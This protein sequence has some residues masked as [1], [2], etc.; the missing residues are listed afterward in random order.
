[1]FVSS[2]GP[3]IE[4]QVMRLSDDAVSAEQHL[5]VLRNRPFR[6]T[7]L[8]HQEIALSR[9]L[10]PQRL[11]RLYIAGQLRPQNVLPDLQTSAVEGFTG[12][13]GLTAASPDPI[14]KSALYHLGSTWPRGVTIDELVA[15]AAMLSSADGKPREISP[16]QREALGHNLVQCMASGLI[17]L[18]SLPDSFVASVSPQ[19]C[20]SRLARAQ[21]RAAGNVTNRRHE[22]VA[23]DEA[24][25]TILQFLDGKR[26]HQALLRE[27]AT[28]V[29]RGDIS[30]MIGGIPA[31]RG[32]ALSGVLTQTLQQSLKKLAT[33]ALL[34]A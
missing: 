28:A 10:S 11:R 26:D 21:A 34:V 32:E 31:T 12:A 1:M 4:A 8:C 13:N 2:F 25:R 27:L 20:A 29:D 19:P 3:L 16:A 6:Q 14:V 7:L 9:H 17:D 18:A 5:D 23:L 15:A 24:A 33:C 22:S 30:I